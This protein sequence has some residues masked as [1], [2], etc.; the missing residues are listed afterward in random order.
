MDDGVVGGG[1]SGVGRLRCNVCTFGIAYEFIIVL[2]AI[3]VDGFSPFN[4]LAFSIGVVG[5]DVLRQVDTFLIIPG[6]GKSGLGGDSVG[7]LCVPM[8]GRGRIAE[9]HTGSSCRNC[10]VDVGVV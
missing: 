7:S 8:I 4:V 3:F 5:L 2:E 9:C 6:D 10:E 1:E